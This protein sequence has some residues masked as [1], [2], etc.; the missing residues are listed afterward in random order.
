MDLWREINW[1]AVQ[2]K[3]CREDVA[4]MNIGRLGVEVFLP[5]LRQEKLVWGVPQLVIKPLFP[6]YLFARFCP[7]SYF[8]LISYARGV[9]RIVSCGEAPLPVDDEIIAMIRSR[10]HND[11]YVRIEPP[12]FQAGDRVMVCEG[13]LQGL[14]GIF[15]RVLSDRERVVILLEAIHYQARVVVERRHLQAVTAD[16]V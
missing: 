13:P 3:P 4:A 9:R 10:V 7:A 16:V 11:G 8:H 2:C 12:Q 1:Y 6:G 15:E 14:R 5:K